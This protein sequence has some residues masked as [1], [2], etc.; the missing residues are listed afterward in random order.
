MKI[1]AKTRAGQEFLY[2]AMSA[3]RV[4]A[5]SADYI[6]KVVNEYK[7]LL[8]TDPAECWHVYEIDQYDKAYYYSCF[9]RFTVRNGI[10]TAKNT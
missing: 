3:R 8:G 2:D 4:S 10:V 7:F 5:R 1:I 9:Q 6:C